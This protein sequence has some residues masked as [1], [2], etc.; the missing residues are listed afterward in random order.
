MLTAAGRMQPS[1]LAEVEAAKQD[2]RWEAAYASPKNMVVPADF[3]KALE[4]NKEAQAFFNTLG[5]SNV[6]AIAWRLATAKQPK[7][8]QRRFG[9]LVAMLEKGEFR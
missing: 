9:T 7:T 3:L 2:G 6:Y 1:G 4:E 8:R 5:K